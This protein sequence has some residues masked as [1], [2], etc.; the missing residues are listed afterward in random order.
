MEN[1]IFDSEGG[2]GVVWGICG[3]GWVCGT[4]CLGDAFGRSFL[5]FPIL[6]AQHYFV[7]RSACACLFFSQILC[8]SREQ[9]SQA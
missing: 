6:I 5:L 3:L 7:H 9:D 2:V 4:E 8:P 1:W